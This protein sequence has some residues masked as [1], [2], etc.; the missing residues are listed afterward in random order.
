[1]KRAGIRGSILVTVY[2]LVLRPI[3]EFC[4]AVYHLLLTAAQSEGLERLQL[5][6]LRII[7]GF[8]MKYTEL[9]AVAN[10]NTL[11]ER[12]KRESVSFDKNLQET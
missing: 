9:L 7:F 3:I 4:S 5:R 1:M 8:G 12:K 2:C 6:A 10:M 11:E